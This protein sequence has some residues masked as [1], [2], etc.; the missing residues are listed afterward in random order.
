MARKIKQFQQI[1]DWSNK[2]EL[3]TFGDVKTQTLKLNEE[4][5]EINRAVLKNN[6]KE[7]KDGIGDAIIVL[8]NLAAIAGTSAE[9]CLDMAFTEIYNRKGKMINGTFVKDE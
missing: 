5:G 6:T 4:V 2:R 7:L 9:E 1:L 8:V 3:I